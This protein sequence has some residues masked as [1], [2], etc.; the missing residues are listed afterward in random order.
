MALIHI[1]PGGEVR[2]WQGEGWF[3]SAMDFIAW[4]SGECFALGAMAMGATAPQAVEVAS[5]FNIQTG[6]TIRQ[7]SLAE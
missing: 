4:G 5:K 1:A 6:G 7:L 3:V 2:E